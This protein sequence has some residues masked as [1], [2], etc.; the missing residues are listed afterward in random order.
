MVIMIDICYNHSMMF[1]FNALHMEGTITS[2][3]KVEVFWI[4]VRNVRY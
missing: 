3:L 2:T 4:K 1:F